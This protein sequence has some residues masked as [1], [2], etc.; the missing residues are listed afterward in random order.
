MRIK[1]SITS[2]KTL[3]VPMLV[4]LNIVAYDKLML[5]FAAPILEQLETI[6]II[7]KDNLVLYK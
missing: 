3:T 1:L 7:K 2:L 5:V 6:E 4:K